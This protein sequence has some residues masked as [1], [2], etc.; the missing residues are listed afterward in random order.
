MN[1]SKEGETIAKHYIDFAQTK[2]EEK[3]VSIVFGRLMCSSSQYDKSQKYFE[4]L[5]N[6]PNVEDIAW[7]EVNIAE[8]FVLRVNEKKRENIMIVPM[9][10]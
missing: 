6:D 4:E 2:T 7:I 5:L 8:F 1:V 9:I 3:S 10:E